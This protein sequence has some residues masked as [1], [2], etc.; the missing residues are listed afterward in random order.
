[1]PPVVVQLRTRIPDREMPR[2]AGKLCTDADHAVML[3]GDCD[4]YKPDGE[5]LVLLRRA[6]LAPEL[7]DSAYEALHRLRSYTSDNRGVYTGIKRAE[8][9]MMDGR[10]S[11]NTRTRDESGRIV[12]TASAIVG[13][14]DRQGGRH[15]F[16]RT[17]RFTA[18]EVERWHT[19]VPMVQRV[20]ALLARTMPERYANQRSACLQCHPAWVI[21]ETAFSTLTVNNNV[22]AGVHCDKG[23]YKQGFGVISC[24][25]RGQYSG[26][27]LCFPQFR[28]G[29]DLQHGDVLFFNSH[30]WHGMTPLV[31]ASED[32]E[33]I[34]VVYYL[35]ERMQQ[36]GTPAQEIARAKQVR[37]A[38]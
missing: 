33:R 23:D 26:A 31:P 35:R 29:V 36:C 15:P 10:K 6:A 22:A 11:K 18:T 28:V 1:M 16:C 13:Y 7:L 27:V 9:R 21:G 32:H 19:I 30:D 37:G 17:T 8:L 2:L 5:P 25:R 34:T 20:D 12:Q 4:V 24:V 14:F 3:A 38:L